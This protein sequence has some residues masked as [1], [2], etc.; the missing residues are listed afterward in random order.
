MQEALP[1]SVT[2]VVTAN[3]KPAAFAVVSMRASG[4]SFAQ[5]PDCVRLAW[6]PPRLTIVIGTSLG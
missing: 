4:R 5:L 6:R 2:V 3:R 1:A